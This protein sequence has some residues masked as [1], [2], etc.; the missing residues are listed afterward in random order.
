M[1]HFFCHNCRRNFLRPSAENLTCPNCN[2]SF[3]E[4]VEQPF[5]RRGQYHLSEDQARRWSSAAALLQLLENQLR[6][7]LHLLQA[8]YDESEKK[9][10]FTKLMRESLRNVYV[11]VEK[12]VSQPGCPVCSEDYTV[13]DNVTQLPCGHIY[14][15]ACVM[16]WLESKLT[17]PICRYELVNVVPPVSDLQELS[18]EELLQKIGERQEIDTSL[19]KMNRYAISS[20]SVSRNSSVGR[21]WA[22]ICIGLWRMSFDNMRRKTAALLRSNLPHRY[23]QHLVLIQPRQQQHQ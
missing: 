13:G 2:S 5:R 7:E 14:H 21:S 20:K 18:Q 3:V 17:C 23:F 19:Q 9:P 8:N 1:Q 15:N 11:D 4:E 12:I 6:E 10:K 16:P 22:R